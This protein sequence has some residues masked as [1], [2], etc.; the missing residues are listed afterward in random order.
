[1]IKRKTEMG[2]FINGPQKQP[3]LS[4]SLS[5]GS[6]RQNEETETG[7]PTNALFYNFHPQVQSE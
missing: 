6:W 7:E 3:H 1:M 2:L 4:K 5:N